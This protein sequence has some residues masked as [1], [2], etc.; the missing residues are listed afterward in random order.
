MCKVR[1]CG[2]ERRSRKKESDNLSDLVPNMIETDGE[3]LGEY[4]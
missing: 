2:V 3:N 1:R 4:C